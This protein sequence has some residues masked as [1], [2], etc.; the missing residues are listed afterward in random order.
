MT[1]GLLFRLTVWIFGFVL[2]MPAWASSLQ[3]SPTGLELNAAQN[4]D[5][6]SLSNTGETPIRAQVQVFRW[7]QIDGKDVLEPTRDLVATP[8]MLSIAPGARQL[9]RVVRVGSA[10]TKEGSF[11]II[12][13][14]LPAPSIEKSK[15]GL[16]FLLKYSLPVFIAP[17]EKSD[18]AR[19]SLSAGVLGNA[20][21]VS[22]SGR[23]HARLS[24]VFWV[25]AD[26][27]RHELA[28]GLLGY[29]LA[30]ETMRWSL[31]AGTTR[32]DGYFEAVINDDTNAS[33]LQSSVAP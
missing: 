27:S 3:V 29:V 33:K 10:S 21:E 24:Q 5:A 6:L 7:R 19:P 32:G 18:T 20:L 2:A 22:N 12:V 1:R 28:P 14:E 15:A 23:M 11:R 26:K 8:A 4:A 16:S 31:P 13:S 17:L 25:S 9:V 30:G